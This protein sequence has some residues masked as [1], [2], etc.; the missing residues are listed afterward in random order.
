MAERRVRTLCAA[1][2]VAGAGLALLT[3]SPVAAVELA[4]TSVALDSTDLGAIDFGGD[5]LVQASVTVD[6]TGAPVDPVSGVI[7]VYVSGVAGVFLEDVPIQA[8]GVAYISDPD[9]QPP[10][11]AGTY[12]ISAVFQPAAGSGLQT[13]QTDASA[14]LAVGALTVEPRAR[15]SQPATASDPAAVELRLGGTWV[16]KTGTQPPGSWTIAVQDAAGEEAYATTITHPDTVDAEEAISVPVD[17]E[18][19]PGGEY[20]VLVA[21]LPDPSVAGGVTVSTVPEALLEVPSPG[22]FDWAFAPVPLPTPA[23]VT[24]LALVLV[25]LAAA[26]ATPLVLLRRRRDG[27]SPEVPAEDVGTQ[28]VRTHSPV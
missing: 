6:R 14:T 28:P 13:S 3:P 8:G 12:A 18:L 21:F 24:L 25:L 11:S 4:E 5:W 22:S 15:V 10:L 27:Q 20:T 9:D 17:A 23:F 19:S 7:D 16:E 2:V 26:V 1:A